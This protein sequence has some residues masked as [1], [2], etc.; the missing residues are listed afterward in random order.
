MSWIKNG[1]IILLISIIL[2]FVI[3]FVFTKVFRTTGFSQFFIH[4]NQAGR[5]NKPGFKG[6]FG[7]PLEDYFSSVSI[8]QLGERNSS[9]PTCDFI[10]QKVIFLGDSGTAGFEVNDNQTFVS[11][12]NESCNI[13]SGSGINFGVR[14]HDTHMVLALYE[15]IKKSTPHEKIFYLISSGDFDENID[16]HAYPTMTERFGRIFDGQLI[17]PISKFTLR[18]F[19]LNIR[20][21]LG[22]NFY[23]TTRLISHTQL[24][25]SYLFSQEENN[26]GLDELQSRFTKM[27]VLLTNLATQANKEKAELFVAVYPSLSEGR[28]SDREFLYEE[29][30][31]KKFKDHPLN[32]KVLELEKYIEAK[33][34]LGCLERSEMRFRNDGHL[35]RFGH[36]VISD[37]LRVALL[38][39]DTL[40]LDSLCYK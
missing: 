23:L 21:F 13:H 33:S 25:I 38:N 20:V 39:D 12:I 22:Q 4:D 3:D 24:L 31:T 9:I 1:L 26:V 34:R 5:I 6:S 32:I 16:R 27:E 11:L 15:K 18:D 35:S 30:L 19:Y 10:N 14:A 2:W 36:K 17:S 7:G 28:L 29:L 8:G 40:T 37:F